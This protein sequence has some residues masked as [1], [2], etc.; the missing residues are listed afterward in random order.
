MRSCEVLGLEERLPQT[1]GRVDIMMP[2]R[3]TFARFRQRRIDAAAWGKS[4]VK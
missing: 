2:R 1:A 3:T 4:K